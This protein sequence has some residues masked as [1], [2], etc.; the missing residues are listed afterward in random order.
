MIS[1]D[2]VSMT[3]TVPAVKLVTKRRPSSELSTQPRGSGPASNSAVSRKVP[4]TLSTTETVP[5]A[6]LAT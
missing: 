4:P 1:I 5:L 6:A 3:E 2:C